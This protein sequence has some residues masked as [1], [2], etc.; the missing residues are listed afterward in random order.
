MYKRVFSTLLA[1]LF[2]ATSVAQEREEMIEFGDM[3]R[4]LTREMRESRIIGGDTK[5][6]YEIAPE[7]KIMGDTPYENQGGSPWATSNVLARVAGITKTSC[8]VF[9]AEYGE[10]MAANLK[11][12]I[13][14]VKVIG[15]INISVIAAGSIFLGSMI[16]PVKG[17][18]N[19]QAILNSGIA[20]TERPKALRFDYKVTLSGEPDR[21]RMTGMGP[22]KEV[23][24][25]D[26]PTVVLLLQKRW[27]DKMGMLRAKRV[28]T[29]IVNY[30]EQ[31]EEWQKDVTYPILYGDVSGH[32][33]FI[34]AMEPGYEQ[35]YG[36]NSRGHNVPIMEDSW[37]D[38]SETPTH[39]IL[40]FASSHGGAYIGSPG[41]EMLVDNVRLVY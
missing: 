5:T 37:A 13:E 7:Q 16:E 23:E 3:E 1:L 6:L 41:N 28:G 35:R 15:I 18:S 14:K 31:N 36:L 33:E 34:P 9:P 38:E 27:E 17:V 10:G 26:M 25:M 24:G 20:F 12:R 11:T 32:P 2:V 22:K 39:I 21:I 19:P 8:S 30:R 4:W 40:Q 29:I